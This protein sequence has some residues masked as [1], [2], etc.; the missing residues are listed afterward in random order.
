VSFENIRFTGRVELDSVASRFAH[1]KA[2][3]IAGQIAT[4]AVL[5]N[6]SVTGAVKV[7]HSTM[8][9]MPTARPDSAAGGIMGEYDGLPG[10]THPRYIATL[11]RVYFG[12]RLESEGW[13]A[14]IVGVIN[15]GTVSAVDTLIRGTM[16]CHSALQSVQKLGGV[17]GKNGSTENESSARAFVSLAFENV[18]GTA[19][20]A[21]PQFHPIEAEPRPSRW[22]D[23]FDMFF[24]RERARL[25]TST[26]LNPLPAAIAAPRFR[27][28]T[29]A[30]SNDPATY[31]SA[32][33]DFT[34][35]WTTPSTSAP[36][37]L[38][39]MTPLFTVPFIR[40]SP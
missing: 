9:S 20:S 34:R 3:G 15:G 30:Q 27:M 23:V 12:G 22:P 29:T 17:F 31:A 16:A 18:P 38:R 5:R 36:L 26:Q 32:G 10:S 21:C 19:V 2:G 4:G 6:V 39:W 40:L 7:T 13:G 25:V 11:E 33:F 14:P 37:S 1:R 24:D 28:V 8:L 35:V